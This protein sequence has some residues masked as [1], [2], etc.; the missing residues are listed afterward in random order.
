MD[1]GRRRRI[2]CF[3]S[4]AAGTTLTTSQSLSSSPSL[5]STIGS[6][7]ERPTAAAASP[8]SLFIVVAPLRLD[9][10]SAFSFAFVRS[11]HRSSLAVVSRGKT[12]RPQKA[13]TTP[14]V[15]AFAVTFQ[16]M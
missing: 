12:P 9:F 16:Y 7:E 4:A 11:F 3:F 2:F 15:T 6:A 1:D 13:L 14:C 5:E 8:P 10:R